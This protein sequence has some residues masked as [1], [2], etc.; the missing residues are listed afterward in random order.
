MKKWYQSKTVW[1]AVAQ[2]AV[3]LFMAIKSVDPSVTS[4]GIVA[5]AKSFA[6]FFIRMNTSTAI[7][8]E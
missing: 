5:V 3:G 7:S 2:G 6:D 4:I 8:A 1:L